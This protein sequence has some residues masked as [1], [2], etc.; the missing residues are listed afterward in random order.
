MIRTFKAKLVDTRVL[1][2]EHKL[3]MT[4]PSEDY[5]TFSKRFINFPKEVQ[6]KWKTGY[7][8]GLTNES[9]IFHRMTYTLQKLDIDHSSRTNNSRF[10]VTFDNGMKAN[11]II[12][13][14]E[15]MRMNI[16]H[17][18]YFIDREGEWF[19]KILIVA[20]VG[21]LF[22]LIGNTIGYRQGHAD[23]LKEGK[24]QSQVTNQLPQH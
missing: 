24:A 11:L 23:G 5:F 7:S 6:E 22:A 14:W 10:Q 1:P 16:I 9:N 17:H 20:A 12:S 3:F 21:F 2:T 4:R 13:E 15:I 19:L 18:R 8:L